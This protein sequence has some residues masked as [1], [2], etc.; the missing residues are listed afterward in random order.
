MRHDSAEIWGFRYEL[1]L[2]I[3][4]LNFVFSTGVFVRVVRALKHFISCD[5]QTPYMILTYFNIGKATA[6]KRWA[7]REI[8]TREATQRRNRTPTENSCRF[9]EH[10]E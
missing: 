9:D 3:G 2:N 6:T 10:T 8:F 5:S 1:T 7:Q 4:A